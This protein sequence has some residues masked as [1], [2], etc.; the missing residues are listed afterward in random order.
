M[1]SLNRCVQQKKIQ[2][3]ILMS[4]HKTPVAGK[5][6]TSCVVDAALFMR[7]SLHVGWEPNGML[8]HSGSLVNSP[9]AALSSVIHIESESSLDH[10]LLETN[11][12]YLN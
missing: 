7:K 11:L 10:E 6:Y 12:T 4:G 1:Y 3:G 9:G 5:I 2:T 8:V